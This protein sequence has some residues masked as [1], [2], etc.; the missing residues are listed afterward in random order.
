LHKQR[1]IRWILSR[2][3]YRAAAGVF[4]RGARESVDFVTDILEL[5]SSWTKKTKIMYNASLSYQML[6]FYLWYIVEL[7]LL[8]E[9]E[10]VEFR[11]TEE[12]KEFLSRYHNMTGLMA[13]AAEAAHL[14]GSG[15]VRSSGL[16]FFAVSA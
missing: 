1:G 5:C 3:E 9:S 11:I 6:K 13:A 4:R 16:F 2:V 12:G 14:P 7:G 10:G 8:E 15:K